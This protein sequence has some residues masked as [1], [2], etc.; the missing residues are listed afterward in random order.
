[1]L[2]TKWDICNPL[3]VSWREKVREG[4]FGQKACSA[5]TQ[6]SRCVQTLLSGSEDTEVLKEIT[7]PKA[8][9]HLCQITQVPLFFF[10]SVK[11][12]LICQCLLFTQVHLHVLLFKTWQPPQI[13]RTFSSLLS[14]HSRR[15]I[16]CPDS[17]SYTPTEQSKIV[18]TGMT[19]RLLTGCYA[20]CFRLPRKPLTFIKACVAKAFAKSPGLWEMIRRC[21]ILEWTFKK[22]TGFCL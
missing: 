2:L 17:A 19:C 10:P 14:Q 20:P 6:V 13:K 18:T 4:R 21:G 3:G 5:E 11:L 15:G 8:N 12:S 1:M 22:V 16:P 9:L 7:F